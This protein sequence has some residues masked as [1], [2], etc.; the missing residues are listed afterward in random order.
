LVIIGKVTLQQTTQMPLAENYHM[1]QTFPTYRTDQPLGIS[2]LPRTPGCGNYFSDP[3]RLH[4]TA[5]LMTVN[6]VTITHEVTLRIALREGFDD[7]LT[8]PLG[9]RVFGDAT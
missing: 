8:R 9:R 6:R 2:V 5:K 1:I 7:L 4:A 3:Q